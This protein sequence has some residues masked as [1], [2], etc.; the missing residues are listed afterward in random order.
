MNRK[1]LKR[2][3]TS[4]QV[5]FIYGFIIV[6]FLFIGIYVS[7]EFFKIS[8]YI[9]QVTKENL[10]VTSALASSIVSYHELDQLQT[11]EDMDLPLFEEIRE[12]LIQFAYDNNVEFVYLM[13]NNEQGLAQYI[14][15]NDLSD[16][17]V[18]L[19]TEPFEWEEK[20]WITFNTG[21]KTAELH[22]YQ[23][24]WE[25]LI[26]GFSPIYNATGDIVAVVGV[27][28]D[29]S[30]LIEMQR[31]LRVLTPVL[32]ALFLLI[33]LISFISLS[34]YKTMNQKTKQA[35]KEA[36]HANKAKSQFLSNMSHEIRTPLNAIIGMAQTGVSRL[37]IEEKN[38]SFERINDS[39]KHLLNLV[40]DI[41]DLSKIEEGE[42]K[43]NYEPF[44]L[45]Q[46]CQKLKSI[47]MW[48]VE[49]KQLHFEII[50]DDSIHYALIG[51][52]N[53][54]LQVL[55]N[56]TTNAIKFTPEKGSVIVT[57]KVVSHKDEDVEVQFSVRDNGIGI[58][59]EQKE[60]LFKPFHQ[61]DSSI[62]KKYGGTGLGL[63]ISKTLI[64]LMNGK[65]WF[66]SIYGQGSCFYCSVPFH[67]SHESLET[68]I[69][70]NTIVSGQWEKYKVLVV[71]DVDIN[72][73]VLS[74][75][76]EDTGLQL[77]WVMNGQEAVDKIQRCV[78]DKNYIYHLI[79]MDLQMP[80]LDGLSATRLIRKI[81]DPYASSIPIVAMTAN[82]FDEDVQNCLQAGMNRHIKKPI[83]LSE[84]LQ[85]L[86]EYLDQMC[87]E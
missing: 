83:D 63:I 37:T 14:L 21:E 81:T 78:D 52:E 31:T 64:E 49:K 8:E 39:S 59:E 12:R 82:A 87:I 47:V 48:N 25:N 61:A 43:L 40:N 75:M 19:S 18:N 16:E 17:T 45:S 71:E 74:L 50:E 58:R 28:I 6:F 15:D 9:R 33:M 60:H 29:D 23:D 55:L 67:I 79:L 73:E 65:V 41:L 11:V 42:M 77:D 72:F 53:R 34:H 7:L 22:V 70:Y 54:I 76:L 66:D 85:C 57:I 13:R 56:F 84:L 46:I 86:H 4:K 32:L 62:T 2:E 1:Y 30:S 80:I 69:D 68:T 27:D 10:I 38:Y 51:D 26:S 36:I 20:A 5:I 3:I 24:G 35:T 44:L